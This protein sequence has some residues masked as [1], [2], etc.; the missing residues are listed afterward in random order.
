[1]NTQQ[2]G[3]LAEQQACDYLLQQGLHLQTR[4]YRCLTGEIDLIMLDRTQVV[5]VEV[6]SRKS[7][8]YGHPFETITWQ[9]Q[10]KIIKT[11]RYYLAT[12]GKYDKISSRFDV[13]AVSYQNQQPQIEWVKNAFYA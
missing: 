2:L 5:F 13:V 6:R 7:F 1:M 12:Q 3:V 10:Q 8:A 11:A 9:K 4:N